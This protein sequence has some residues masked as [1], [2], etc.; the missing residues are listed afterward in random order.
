MASSILLSTVLLLCVNLVVGIPFLDA[1][2]TTTTPPA[3]YY[4]N[5]K[6][7]NGNHK[8]TGTNKTNLWVYSH[9]TG[10]GL[11]DAGLSSNKSVAWEGYLN[12]TQ[13]LFTYENNQ[14]GPWPMSISTGPY[15]RR[16]SPESGGIPF[17]TVLWPMLLTLSLDRMESCYHQ[18]CRHPLGWVL[19]QLF[20]P[21]IQ[22]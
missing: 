9:H 5:T 21:P 16:F 19:L 3:R 10:A 8:D 18:H 14:I 17:N 12:G 11:G 20:W 7:V 2:Q 13:Q 22:L 15:Q 1:R 6:V 4:L